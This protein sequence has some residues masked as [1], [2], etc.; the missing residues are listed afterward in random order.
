MLAFRG[1]RSEF[2]AADEV[3][4]ENKKQNKEKESNRLASA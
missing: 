1:T 3:F 2:T 4:L